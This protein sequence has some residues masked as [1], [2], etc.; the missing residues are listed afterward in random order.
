MSDEAYDEHEDHDEHEDE[1]GEELGDALEN[2]FEW[3]LDPEAAHWVLIVTGSHLRAEMAD[4]PLA[5][6]LQQKIE[7]WA[8]RQ[9]E[10]L[11]IPVV[12]VVCSDVW[13]L[14]QE[15]LQKLPTIAIGGP[16]V[17]VLSADFAQGIPAEVLQENRI[18]MQLDP[19]FV[20]LRVCLWGIDHEHTA[21][22]MKLFDETYLEDY[23]K[24]VATQVEPDVGG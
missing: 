23:M 7:A 1:L 14:H 3:E 18:F 19:D 4:R 21:E 8:A 13:Y 24:A 20:D 11:Q 5:Y 17:N 22:C 15:E 12:P 6:E 2:A 10:A 16:G 9:G